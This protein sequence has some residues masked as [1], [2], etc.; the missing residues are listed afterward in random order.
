MCP[1]CGKAVSP[2]ESYVLVRN[3][4]SGTIHDAHIGCAKEKAQG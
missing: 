1:F 2:M 3:Q 4:I